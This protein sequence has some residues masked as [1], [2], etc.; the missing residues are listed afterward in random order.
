MPMVN[1]KNYVIKKQAEWGREIKIKD[2]VEKADLSRDTVS[3]LWN[4]K[5]KNIHQDTLFKL[6]EFFGVPRGEPIPFVIYDP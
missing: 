2:I 1:L 5:T 4:G 6:C 3:R